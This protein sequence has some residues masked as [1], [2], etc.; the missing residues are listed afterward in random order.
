MKMKNLVL[1]ALL[2]L[3][4]AGCTKSESDNSNAANPGTNAPA[5]TNSQPA[6]N[7]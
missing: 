4:A 6:T 7:K 1:G 3:L 5:M 2:L